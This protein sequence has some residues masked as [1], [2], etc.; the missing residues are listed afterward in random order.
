MPWLWRKAMRPRPSGLE[1][2]GTPCVPIR[3]GAQAQMVASRKGGEKWRGEA[4]QSGSR[5]AGFV[6][7]PA[8]FPGR[9]CASLARSREG[10]I[11]GDLGEKVMELEGCKISCWPDYPCNG[12]LPEGGRIRRVCVWGGFGGARWKAQSLEL[13][14]LCKVCY[15]LPGVCTLEV[16][17]L[18]KG[19]YCKVLR[20]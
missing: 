8:R 7:V 16:A 5:L 15:P 2:A 1:P 3:A 17:F 14:C 12:W 19:S 10:V 6:A 18:Q 9:G 13:L 20:F 4:A 11:A